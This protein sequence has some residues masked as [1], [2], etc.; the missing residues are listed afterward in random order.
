MVLSCKSEMVLNDEEKASKRC[1]VG[2]GELNESEPFEEVSKQLLVG[3][4][5]GLRL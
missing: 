2:V 3:E 5:I 4:T 1:Q